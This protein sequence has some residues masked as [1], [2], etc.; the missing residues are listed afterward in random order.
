MNA[1]SCPLEKARVNGQFI[2]GSPEMSGDLG[3]LLPALIPASKDK[4]VDGAIH[5]VSFQQTSNDVQF[6]Y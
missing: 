2:L 4:T 3:H 5:K 6:S 1:D